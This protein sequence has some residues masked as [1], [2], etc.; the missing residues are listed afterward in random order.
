MKDSRLDGTHVPDKKREELPSR[1][2]R[3][4]DQV[5][6]YR[7]TKN[8]IKV[9]LLY[10]EI[11]L[12]VAND[13]SHWSHNFGNKLYDLQFDFQ[14][15]HLTMYSKGRQFRF[16]DQEICDVSSQLRKHGKKIYI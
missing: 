14:G 10:Y 1:Y 16:L 15:A 3:I 13:N 7:V 11:E 2:R 9:T 5:K 6:N 4:N 8:L 12:P